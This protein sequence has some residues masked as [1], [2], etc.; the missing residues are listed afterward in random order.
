MTRIRAIFAIAAAAACLVAS[1]PVPAGAGNWGDKQTARRIVAGNVYTLD[2]RGQTVFDPG[3]RKG[4]RTLTLYANVT[5][6]PAGSSARRALA[7][8]G[9]RVW[10]E[11]VNPTDETGFLGYIP[12]PVYGDDSILIAHTWEHGATP[13]RGWRAKIHITAFDAAG[14]PRAVPLT[15]RTR[16][17]KILDRRR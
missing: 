12:I 11:Q 6:P 13:G 9:W 3:P 16:G 4:L 7:R 5:L 15:V 10:F 8:G 1:V 14:R 2:V 17:I